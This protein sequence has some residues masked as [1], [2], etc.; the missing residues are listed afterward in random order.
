MINLNLESKI[1]QNYRIKKISVQSLFGLF[2]YDIPLNDSGVTILIGVNGSGKTTIFRIVH[3]IFNAEF[4]NIINVDFKSFE[5]VFENDDFI[6]CEK[7]VQS[8]NF[9]DLSLSFVRNKK[10]ESESD[11]TYGLQKLCEQ[12]KILKDFTI[13]VKSGDLK[14]RHQFIKLVSNPENSEIT[15]KIDEITN[16]LK[17]TLN[18]LGN[19]HFIET[20]RLQLNDSC[21]DDSRSG[22]IRRRYRSDSTGRKVVD[23]VY[24]EFS[25]P[26]YRSR[27]KEYANDLS[28]II[29]SKRSNYFAESQDVEKK[30]LYEFLDAPIFDL[31]DSIF[32]ELE[33]IESDTSNMKKHMEKLLKLGIYRSDEISQIGDLSLLDKKLKDLKQFK[34]FKN[35]S[36]KTDSSKDVARLLDFSLKSSLLKSYAVN[37]RKKLDIFLDL[38]AKIE[39]FVNNLN[40]LFTHKNMEIDLEK[41]FVFRIKDG[42]QEGRIIDPD[43]LSSG[44]QH[45]V[46]LNYELIFKTEN[47]SV[48]LIDEPEISLHIL[49]QKKFIDNLLEI[50]KANNLNIIVATHSPD[51]VDKHR[52]RV[53]VLSD[54]YCKEA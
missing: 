37:M 28:K 34:E 45:E 53:H 19:S 16:E 31:Q 12:S 35:N 7:V 47:N 33:N 54:I 22:P 46:I 52:K 4:H 14:L 10:Y 27:I 26:P 50:A 51:I 8:T 15:Y 41:G 42:L 44:E 6:K 36:I 49:W 39:I 18:D 23:Y 43:D 9:N 13:T 24:E 30:T 40:T 32:R 29:K 48:I 11:F 38:E 3:N 20:Q 21:I 5:I 25:K 1:N 17:N 2:D